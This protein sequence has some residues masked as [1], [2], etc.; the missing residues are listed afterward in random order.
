M[1]CYAEWAHIRLYPRT[2]WNVV[3]QRITLNLNVMPCGFHLAH[4][5]IIDLMC[6]AP[7]VRFSSTEEAQRA[8]RERQGAFLLN[9]SVVLRVLQ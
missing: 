5:L 3:C 9:G 4:T 8:V 7:Q 6:H 2:D 1:T